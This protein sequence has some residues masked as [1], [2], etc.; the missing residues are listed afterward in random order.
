MRTTGSFRQRRRAGWGMAAALPAALLTALVA[1]GCGT[2]QGPVVTVATVGEAT[3]H[4][5]TMVRTVRAEALLY[6]LHEAVLIPKISAPIERFTVQRGDR[7]HRGELL[8]VLENQDLKAAVTQAQGAYQQAEAK[9]LSL[10][11]ATL[12]EQLRAAK[13]TL[14]SDQQALAAARRTYH[15]R[16]HLY[17]QGALPLITLE[18]AHVTYTQALAAYREAQQHLQR[19]TSVG[20]QQMIREAAGQVA[21]AKG[22]YQAAQARL[23]YSYIRSPMDGVVASRPLYPGQMATSSTPLFTLVD[24]RQIVARAHVSQD[25]AA[26]V[27]VGNPATITSDSGVSTRGKVTVVSPALDPNSTTVQIWAQAPNPGERLRP[28]SSAELTVRVG[29]VANALVIPNSAVL[30]NSIGGTSVMVVVNGKAESRPVTVGLVQNGAAQIVSGLEPG[31]TVVT[32]G[33][34]GLPS[35]TRVKAAA[36][37]KA[38]ER[39]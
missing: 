36:A 9:Y 15:S 22:Q 33:A 2:A 14:G 17:A 28:G 31:E 35:G 6:P 10:T 1:A 32:T 29:T 30:T 37:D 21:M 18:Q 11:G 34:F 38:A 26:L 23:A 4:R 13:L 19:L 27:A 25:E 20:R 3:A 8:A 16:Q 5:A 24:R 39:S 12:P 7:V